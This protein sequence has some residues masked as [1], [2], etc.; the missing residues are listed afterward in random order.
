VSAENAEILNRVFARRRFVC[1]IGIDGSG[2]TTQARRLVEEAGD[3]PHPPHYIWCRSARWVSGC[4][5]KLAKS[6][7]RKR[8]GA[9]EE[10]ADR[11]VRNKVFSKKWVATLY[12]YLTLLE[13]RGQVLCCLAPA[14]LGGWSVVCDRYLDDAIADLAANYNLDRNGITAMLRNP[15]LGVFPRPDVTVY[16]RISAETSAARK[17]DVNV[18]SMD[19]LRDRARVYDAL[20]ELQGYPVVDGERTPDEVYQEIIA[21]LARRF[22][23]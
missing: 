23:Q 14:R 5:V 3:L 6:A 13:Y 15:V 22:A 4:V 11:A 16:V 12:T 20:A 8:A 21:V 2:K 7:A 1:L 19:Y 17:D 10:S 18:P 9:A